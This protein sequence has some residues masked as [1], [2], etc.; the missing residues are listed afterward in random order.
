MEPTRSAF[1]PV[2]TP[3]AFVVNG[4]AL[5]PPRALIVPPI[6]PR[7]AISNARPLPTLLARMQGN[8]RAEEPP[9]ADRQPSSAPPPVPRALFEY[10]IPNC[11][12]FAITWVS[13]RNAP[14][15]GFR[16]PPISPACWA[17]ANG[18]MT[19]T[20]AT[21]AASTHL[22][23]PLKRRSRLTIALPPQ[24]CLPREHPPSGRLYGRRA[25]RLQGSLQHS[26]K[27]AMAGGASE[28]YRA[29]R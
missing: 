8:C 21:T 22:T 14:D 27:S 11:E 6:E 19:S 13:A 12:V 15:L 3:V 20:S 7:V 10:R 17:I 28:S 29:Q 26:P 18:E 2:A 4:F 9:G 24:I 16:L 25:G 1:R 23:S 5:S